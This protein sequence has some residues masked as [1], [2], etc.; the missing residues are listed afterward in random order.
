M[1]ALI[2][3][4]VGVLATAFSQSS[5]AQE[6][7]PQRHVTLVVPFAAGG[8]FDVIGRIIARG[9]SEKWGQQVIVE[10]KP[11]AAGDIGA[12]Q[13]AKSAPD[14]YSLLLVSDGLLSN[15]ALAKARPFD[16]LKSF[17]PITLAARSPQ[18]LVAGPASKIRSLSELVAQAHTGGRILNYGT[19][20]SGTPGHLVVELLAKSGKLNLAHVPYRGGAPAL[21]DLLGSQI[22]LVSTGLPALLG[23]IHAGSIVPLAVSSEKRFPS[24]PNVPAMAEVVPG[25]AVDTWYGVVG[26]AK[27]PTNLRDQIHADIVS[28]LTSPTLSKR[29]IDMG[30]EPTNLGP[31][32]FEAAMARD[33]PRWREIVALAGIKPE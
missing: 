25:V 7:Y 31:A 21:S 17:T 13:V 2:V 20:G 14:G 12:A 29:L 26:P 8:S 5:Q 23:A 30:F 28:V 6:R 32:D 18:I 33:L 4:F 19:A 24:L 1:K 15:D 11:G 10:N 3:A 22:E 27:L 9:L 16:P